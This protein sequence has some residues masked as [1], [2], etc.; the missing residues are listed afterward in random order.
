[1][2]LLFPSKDP[3]RWSYFSLPSLALL[4]GVLSYF[5]PFFLGSFD[6]DSRNSSVFS[7]TTTGHCS[8]QSPHIPPFA[9]LHTYTSSHTKSQSPSAHVL[10]PSSHPTRIKIIIIAIHP[11]R[12]HPNPFP[13]SHPKPHRSFQTQL[14][15]SHRRSQ[16]LP[17]DPSLK[18][19][20]TC[21]SR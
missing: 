17:P 21:S 4:V 18:P 10:P 13:R 5:L 9:P 20:P 12:L 1:M 2:Y 6:F 16:P 15:A 3:K 8:Q 19:L 14:I 11:L 7:R